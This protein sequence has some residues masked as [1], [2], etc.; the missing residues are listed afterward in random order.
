MLYPLRHLYA[1]DLKKNSPFSYH[2]VYFLITN[3]F[4]TDLKVIINIHFAQYITL[5][6]TT[7]CYFDH[8]SPT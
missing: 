2:G 3:T 6:P 7:T 5:I 8:E 4:R 1:N